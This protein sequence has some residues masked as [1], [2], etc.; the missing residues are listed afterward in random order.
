MNG[1]LATARGL[2]SGSLNLWP[3]Q[4]AVEY[5]Y[6]MDAFHVFG[7]VKKMRETAQRGSLNILSETPGATVF[8]D[9]KKQ[10]EAPQELRGLLPGPH[11]IE[12][13]A[14]GHARKVMS[15]AVV[16]G[17]PIDREV[18]LAK[19]PSMDAPT[20]AIEELAAATRRKSATA[21]G[22]GLLKGLGADQAIVLVASARRDRFD[23]RGWA[24]GPEGAV[25]IR[26]KIGDDLIEELNTI[27]SKSFGLIAPS[28]GEAEN[29]SLGG[30][31]TKSLVEVTAEDGSKTLTPKP[32]IDEPFYETWWFWTA[33]GGVV[34]TAVGVAIG[35]VLSAEPDVP[36]GNLGITL[37][38]VP[39]R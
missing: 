34:A 11:W 24:I 19:A 3:E 7:Y 6:D 17:A 1:E 5:A 33:A 25:A 2:I 18:K 16:T 39:V 29:V 20:K 38:R 21:L 9:G 10:G 12:V 36:R 22:S 26:G 23:I 27:L 8:L 35:V 15:I 13:E 30:P 37:N 14:D 31:P 4:K 28:E 32:E